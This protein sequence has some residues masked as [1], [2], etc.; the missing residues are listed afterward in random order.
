MTAECKL[1]INTDNTSAQVDLMLK[2][3]YKYWREGATN[4]NIK[5]Y[6]EL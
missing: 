2:N 6:T 1:S 3:I 4:L 5:Q